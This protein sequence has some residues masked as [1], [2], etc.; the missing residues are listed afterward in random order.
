MSAIHE[1]PIRVLVDIVHHRNI[2]QQSLDIP[3]LVLHIP[4]LVAL[5]CQHFDTTN[6]FRFCR[7]LLLGC[8]FERLHGNRSHFRKSAQVGL[9]HLLPCRFLPG[10][11]SQISCA[12][13]FL[14]N[15]LQGH[16]LENRFPIVP[17]PAQNPRHIEIGKVLIQETTFVHRRL[18][19]FRLLHIDSRH[20]LH[21]SVINHH[22]A[23]QVHNQPSTIHT[24][25]EPFANRNARLI[26]RGIRLCH[27][28][29]RS[30]LIGFR[31]FDGCR[32]F[33]IIHHF[34]RRKLAFPSVPRNV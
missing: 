27:L 25:H 30:K 15:K 32:G 19:I 33:G 24:I 14:T 7:S 12:S 8:F 5:H 22:G 6:G 2:F 1:R 28:F 26:G 20:R 31:E 16:T 10:Q 11:S 21:T 9:L 29:G 17:R 23:Q 13:S 18:R 3:I 4:L 34:R